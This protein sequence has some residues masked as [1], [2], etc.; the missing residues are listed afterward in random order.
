M[1][2]LRLSL[3]KQFYDM[4]E[5]GFKREEYRELKDYWYRRL[6]NMDG[7]FQHYDYITFSYGYTKRTMT[8][9]FNGV[10]IGYGVPEWGGSYSLGTFCIS[11]GVLVSKTDKDGK[12]IK[13]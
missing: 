4:I 10:R 2:V 13:C 6:T 8:Y 1:R 5:S 3:K 12:L 11:I 7:S 9:R